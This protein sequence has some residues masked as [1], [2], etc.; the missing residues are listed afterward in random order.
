[1]PV[2][3]GGIGKPETHLGLDR[4]VVFDSSHCPHTARVVPELQHFLFDDELVAGHDRAAESSI[5]DAHE[6]GE[7]ARFS[8]SVE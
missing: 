6:I 7:F 5:G 4:N 3:T 2:L 8:V 1:L